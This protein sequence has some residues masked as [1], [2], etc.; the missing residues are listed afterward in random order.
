MSGASR[1]EFLRAAAAAA[2]AVAA[3]LPVPGRLRADSAQAT[4]AVRKDSDVGQF[5][6]T[7]CAMQ[8]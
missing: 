8:M 1:R 3:G 5:C 7:G 2:T 6:G 4:S